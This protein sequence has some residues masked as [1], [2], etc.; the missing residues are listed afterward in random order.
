[1]LTGSLTASKWISNLV[2]YQYF[3]AFGALL[4]SKLK[5]IPTVHLQIC[6]SNLGNAQFKR[7]GLHTER[8]GGGDL[9]LLMDDSPS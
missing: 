8:E 6:L 9:S 2:E 5:K 7:E 1:M 4:L 3:V